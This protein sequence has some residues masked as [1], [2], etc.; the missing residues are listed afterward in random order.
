[1]N[2]LASLSEVARMIESGRTLALAG[3]GRV[4]FSL[5]VGNWIGGTSHYV[6]G[7][8]GGMKCDNLIH[9][10]DLGA[11]GTVRFAR[12]GADEMARLTA[13]IPANGFTHVI[14]PS[15]SASLRAFAQQPALGREDR[16]PL[17]GWVA[18]VDLDALH[19]ARPQVFSGQR[20]QFEFD[21]LVAAHVTLPEGRRAVLTV[22]NPFEPA[23]DHVIE[24]DATAFS[25]VDCFVDG[26]R[27]RL[28][29]FLARSGYA[30][31]RLPLIAEGEGPSHNVSFQAVECVSGRVDFFAPVSAGL[32]YRIARPLAER[33]R[34]FAG[35]A[36]GGE[37]GG[38]VAF[39][40]NCI[41]N[42]LYG[43][44]GTSPGCDVHGPLTFGEIGDR[45][46]N[47]TVVKLEIR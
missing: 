38:L 35:S 18:G 40:C 32:K 15:G 9:V 26:R 8:Q 47:Q 13:E 42:H 46:L 39:S 30:H 33:E 1:M 17:V 44:L 10:T 22:V 6:V 41:L 34:D 11:L 3:P 4:L 25:V 23:E 21:A 14:V 27:E 45:L 20:R 37:T 36:S 7:P 24:F 29:D 28:A 2:Q 16:G 31:G 12:Y 43:Y 5:P 19:G